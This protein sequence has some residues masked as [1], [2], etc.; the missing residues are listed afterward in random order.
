MTRQK[1]LWKAEDQKDRLSE[2]TAQ[3]ENSA[4][5]RSLRRDVRSLGALL[6]RVLVEQ[7][8]QE[9][10]D[11]VEGLR[12]LMIRHRER[13]IHSARAAAHSEL[14]ANAQAMI[15][16]MDV[17]RAYQVTKAF[18]IYF[19]L[20]DLAETNHRKR[21]RRARQLHRQHALPGSFRGTLLR[22]KEAGMPAKA[23]L[24]ALQQI[25]VT[26]VFTAHPTEVARQ[27]VLLKRRRIAEQLE[28]LDRLPLTVGE[29]LRCEQIIHAEITSL[30]QTLPRIYTEVAESV[31]D[32]YGM[33]LDAEELPNL[34][35]FGSWIGG[36]RDGN[37]LVKPEC[38]KDALELARN[39]ILREYIRDVEFLSDCLS[40]S[41]RQ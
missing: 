26:P 31:R 30:W 35:S 28:R 12:Q 19:E 40:S 8:G 32:V 25:V 10:F 4:K 22:M 34:L 16:A 6:G 37:P 41:L 21:R 17:S 39:M 3:S 27:T 38:V 29:A 14:M 11:T 13:V 20:A 23:A 24:A 5:D 7:C 9:L 2:L 1:P 18:A 15:S 36:D 33:A